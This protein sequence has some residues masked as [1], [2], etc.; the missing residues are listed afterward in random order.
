MRL[1]LVQTPRVLG[2]VCEAVPELGSLDR[3]FV[4]RHA[5][6]RECLEYLALT[7]DMST[8]LSE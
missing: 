6:S 5:V 1:L 8:T 3:R 2:L 4:D 7:I